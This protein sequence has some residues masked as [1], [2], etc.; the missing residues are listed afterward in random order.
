MELLGLA[1]WG[2]DSVPSTSR[3]QPSICGHGKGRGPL[4][5]FPVSSRPMGW[6]EE[7][8]EKLLGV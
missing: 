3:E 7:E 6:W 1:I 5:E 4:S 2:L 8:E